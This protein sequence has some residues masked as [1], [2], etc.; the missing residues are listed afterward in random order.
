MDEDAPAPAE[1]A[2]PAIISDFGAALVANAEAGRLLGKFRNRYVVGFSQ[3]SLPVRTLITSGLAEDVFDGALTFV[4][5][6]VFAPLQPAMS[7]GLYGGKAITL[8]TEFDTLVFGAGVLEDDGS[9]PGRYRHYAVPGAGH[10]PSA[11]EHRVRARGWRDRARCDGQCPRCRRR[12]HAGPAGATLE[13]DEADMFMRAGLCEGST[14]TE[15]YR[16]RYGQF[17]NIAPCP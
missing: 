3:T 13:E 10:A 1:V 2:D 15:N 17:V 16:D 8:N 14:Y 11:D 4:N 9:T 6:F 5:A 12:R 7:A